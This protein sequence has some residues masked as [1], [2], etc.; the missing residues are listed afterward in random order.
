MDSLWFVLCFRLRMK[1]LQ[2]GV[3][4]I[5]EDSICLVQS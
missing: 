1:M 4:R 3:L 5:L 2:S